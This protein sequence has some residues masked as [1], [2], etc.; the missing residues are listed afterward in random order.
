MN[1]NQ[2][3]RNIHLLS[4]VEKLSEREWGANQRILTYDGHSIAYYSKV[5]KDSNYD[6][7]YGRNVN[8][9]QSIPIKSIT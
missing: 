2:S 6:K 3:R 7:I 1:N 8:P 5:P 9:K 4:K